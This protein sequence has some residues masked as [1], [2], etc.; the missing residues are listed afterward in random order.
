MLSSRVL[1]SPACV[2]AH[3]S[4]LI[5]ENSVLWPFFLLLPPGNIASSLSRYPPNRTVGSVAEEGNKTNS[6]PLRWQREREM[7]LCS[8]FFSSGGDVFPVISQITR[9]LGITRVLFSRNSLETGGHPGT[10]Q[11]TNPAIV[12]GMKRMESHDR[13]VWMEV[14]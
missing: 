10:I 13:F 8:L 7:L 11:E 3:L 1:P 6:M 5:K 12:I 4:H 14:I 2:S 9:N